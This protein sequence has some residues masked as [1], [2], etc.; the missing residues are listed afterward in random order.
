MHELIGDTSGSATHLLGDRLLG[1]NP[2]RAVA[3]AD[4]KLRG[5]GNG[6]AAVPSRADLW[7]LWP[8]QRTACSLQGETEARSK[9][10]QR[11]DGVPA[12]SDRNWPWSAVHVSPAAEAGEAAM[13]SCR[14]NRTYNGKCWGENLEF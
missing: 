3:L 14:T 11:E 2:C 1:G 13:H 12:P 5:A 9:E 8:W 6:P 10:W 7:V 4:D